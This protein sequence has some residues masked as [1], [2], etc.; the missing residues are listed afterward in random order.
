MI[1][2]AQSRQAEFEQNINGKSFVSKKMKCEYQLNKGVDISNFYTLNSCAMMMTGENLSL[3]GAPT[4][5]DMET[6]LSFCQF[7]GVYGLE[8]QLDNLPFARTTMF[9]MKYSGDSCD[10]CEE[11]VA[12]E[13]IYG[14][15]QFSCE[16]FA[17]ASFP[18]VYSS[19]ARKV[20]K[21]VSDIYYIT[22]NRRI[23][24]GA[25]ATRYGMDDIYITFVSTRPA[26]RKNGLAAKVI[27]HIISQNPGRN[28]ILM[29]EEKLKNFYTK[30]G[31]VHTDNVYLYTLREESY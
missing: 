21:G 22:E 26:K 18:T 10:N 27:R 8:T 3:R 2:S 12:N 15:S 17:G 11:I 9:L 5:E 7:L 25:L 1:K 20:N 30:L 16:H 28:V 4:D 14:F 6:I 31:F 13:N 29:C 19:L 24:S 23:V